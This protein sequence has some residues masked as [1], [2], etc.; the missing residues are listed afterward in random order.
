[1]RVSLLWIQGGWELRD[2]VG[3]SVLR[4]LGSIPFYSRR[5]VLERCAGSG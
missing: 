5:G 4:A 1:M 2:L 3:F